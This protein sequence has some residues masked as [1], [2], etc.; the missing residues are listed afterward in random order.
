MEYVSASSAPSLPAGLKTLIEKERDLIVDCR[1]A[2]ID[3]RKHTLNDAFEIALSGGGIRSVLRASKIQN[4]ELQLRRVRGTSD[5]TF[6]NNRSADAAKSKPVAFAANPN[7][8]TT[9]YL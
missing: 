5:K 9:P 3:V 1:K 2:A 7:E 6:A 8:N 4:I